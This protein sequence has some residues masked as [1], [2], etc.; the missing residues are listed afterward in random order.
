MIDNFD[1]A[2]DGS[3][4]ILNNQINLASAYSEITLQVPIS[5]AYIV[6]S[7]K[8]LTSVSFFMSVHWCES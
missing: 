1:F 8:L 5:S 4:G 7:H 3:I 6:I 2:K